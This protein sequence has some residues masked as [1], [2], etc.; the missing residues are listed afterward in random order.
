MPL[1]KWPAYSEQMFLIVWI[2]SI[3]NSLH[4]LIH[5]VLCKNNFN[6]H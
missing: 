5:G 6:A 3:K 4:C 2:V 1:T